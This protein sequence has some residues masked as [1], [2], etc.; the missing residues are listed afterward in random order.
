MTKSRNGLAFVATLCLILTLFFFRYYNIKNIITITNNSDDIIEHME[1]ISETGNTLRTLDNLLPS[2]SIKINLE[3]YQSAK[4]INLIYY[5]DNMQSSESFGI[6]T[7]KDEHSSF[8]KIIITDV[9]ENGEMNVE[10][11]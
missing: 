2:I 6:K 7:S 3:A 1:L 5:Y 11:K 9:Y 4:D 10:V 8:N